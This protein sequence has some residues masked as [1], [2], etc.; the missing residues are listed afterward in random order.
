[1]ADQ[2][3]IWYG[4][5]SNQASH[6]LRAQSPCGQ[7]Q[8]EKG[9][10]PWIWML[11]HSWC[12]ILV[13]LF[14]VCY[15]VFGREGGRRRSCWEKRGGIF[16][17]KRRRFENIAPLPTLTRN[18]GR[19]TLLRWLESYTKKHVWGDIRN[20]SWFSFQTICI[21]DCTFKFL[22]ERLDLFHLGKHH[23]GM[24]KLSSN[25]LLFFYANIIESWSPLLLQRRFALISIPWSR[26]SN[27]KQ[28]SL[29]RRITPDLPG[30]N[31]S[32]RQTTFHWRWP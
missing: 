20:P 11:E 30:S 1:M 8:Q 5:S 27:A 25:F 15:I 31:C 19:L 4:C 3:R 32:L 29:N 14:E 13:C 12:L 26:V 22:D 9:Q 10:R 21:S 24:M 7:R 17:R 6:S 16:K 18:E 28:P 2:Q 23:G